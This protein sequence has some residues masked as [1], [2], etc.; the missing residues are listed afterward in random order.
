MVMLIVEQQKSKR[1]KIQHAGRKITNGGGWVS[2]RTE[3][4]SRKEKCNVL[5]RKP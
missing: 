1:V 3:R 4:K 2:K 5:L